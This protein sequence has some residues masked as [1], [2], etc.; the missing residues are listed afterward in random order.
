MDSPGRP[1][2]MKVAYL[3]SE[4][5]LV[6]HTFIRRE[7]LGVEKCG[8]E[9]VRLAI[10]KPSRMELPDPVDQQEYDKTIGVLNRGARLLLDVAALALSRPL[11]WLRTAF[12]TLARAM[13]SSRGL[14]PH[15]AYFAEACS[16]C[17]ILRRLGVHHVHAH[18][19]LNATMVAL[20]AKRLG[21]PGYSFQVHGPA[22]FDAP[23]FLHMPEKVAGARF[24]TA[25]TDY[26][27][28]QT[29]RWSVPEH[30][31]KI[32]LIRCGV[33]RTFIADEAVAVPDVPRLLSIGR[34]TL[35]KAQ[36]LLVEAVARLVQEGRKLEVILIGT[37]ELRARLE[38]DI[39][40]RGVGHALKLVGV[41]DGKGVRDALLSSRALVLPSFN[42]GLPVVIMEAF[43]LFR[44]AIVTQIAG[45]PEL[46]V[47][48]R[49]G[50]VIPAGNVDLLADAM[51]EA[52]DAP[53]ARLQAM[54][55]AGAAVVREKHDSAREA[56]KLAELFL[57]TRSAS[58]FPR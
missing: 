12:W 13:R 14:L 34:L 58:G 36:P 27:R 35:P 50:W 49:N 16:I 9:V 48:G 5:P 37:G 1:P 45:I 43:A 31:N 20:L 10:R 23:I 22:E 28:A 54:G 44:P 52:L 8:I 30:W 6:T 29:M 3:C 46:V 39:Q 51:R 33:D 24:V 2:L 17:R 18:F 4:Y 19:G 26:A 15:V 53:V 40:E 42:E 56:A 38:R 11:V 47:H 55:A 25:I 32:H 41:K 57:A 21:G 7:I